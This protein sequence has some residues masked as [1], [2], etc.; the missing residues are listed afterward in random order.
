MSHDRFTA[1]ASV[2]EFTIAAIRPDGTARPPVPIWGVLLDGGLHVRAAYGAKS[3]WHR[4]A[5]AS[6]R[7]RISARGESE[8]VS[9]APADPA[10]NDRVD[11]AYREKYGARYA[12]IV[13]TIVGPEHRASTLVLTPSA[14]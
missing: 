14:D 9:V 7:A 12:S 13:E 8:D 2:E 4:I 3:A 5:L 1:I 6:G 10:L 11:A